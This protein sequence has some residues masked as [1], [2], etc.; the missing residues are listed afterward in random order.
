MTIVTSLKMC[1]KGI[2][3]EC[4]NYT[5]SFI[6]LLLVTAVMA[7]FDLIFPL[8]QESLYNSPILAIEKYEYWRLFSSFLVNYTSFPFGLLLLFFLFWVLKT[9]MVALVLPCLCLVIQTVDSVR[10]GGIVQANLRH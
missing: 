10:P 6:L 3:T 2:Y 7:I 5:F 8:L 4:T 1:C 9:S